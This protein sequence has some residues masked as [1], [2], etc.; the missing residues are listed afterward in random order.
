MISIFTATKE[1]SLRFTG[2]KVEMVQLQNQE[3][4]F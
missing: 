1:K 2:D 3:K 4:K